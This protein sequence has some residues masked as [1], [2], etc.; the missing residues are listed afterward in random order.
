MATNN[1]LN[2][3][4]TTPFPTINGG[5]G[6]SSPTA[7][8]VLVAEGASAFT[9]IVLGAGQVLI[10]TTASDP[11][12]AAL[13]AGNG[14]SISS[15]SGSITISSTGGFTWNEVTGTSASMVVDNGYISSNAGL[16]TLTLPT[17]SAVGDELA[18]AG[19]GAGGWKVAQNASQLIHIGSS[20]TTTG[21]GGSVAS[22]NAFDALTLVCIT[23]NTAW[24]LTSG[25]QS[26]GLTIV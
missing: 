26:A 22:V 12:A 11:T 25:P 15:A 2:A 16:V 21:T 9:P 7:H 24:T 18:V 3:N 8:G 10:G 19:K 5:T 13:T 20:V 1:A 17:T 23:A 14:V 6:V 4:S